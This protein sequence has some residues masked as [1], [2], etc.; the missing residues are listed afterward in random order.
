MWVSS[1]VYKR[2]KQVAK[3]EPETLE[4][5]V[6]LEEG[7]RVQDAIARCRATCDREF[8]ET[9]AQAIE[10]ATAVLRKCEIAFE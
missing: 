5:T 2:V 1:V 7:D 4:L 10:Q 8:G 9:S 6:L 3:F